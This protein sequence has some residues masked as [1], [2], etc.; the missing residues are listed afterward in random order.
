MQRA[1]WAAQRVGTRQLGREQARPAR[2][3]PVTVAP[4]QHEKTSGT[5]VLEAGEKGTRGAAQRQR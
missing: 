1:Y 4:K 5:A 2:P 3:E